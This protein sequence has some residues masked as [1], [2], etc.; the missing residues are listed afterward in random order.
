M[1]EAQAPPWQNGSTGSSPSVGAEARRVGNPNWVRG[2][3]SPNPSGRP[4]GSTP[5]TKLMER[6][7]ADA[8]GIVDAII[9]RALEGDTG[10]ASLIMSRLLPGLKPQSAPVEFE[11]DAAMPAA[12]QIEQIISAIAAGGVPTDVGKQLIDAIE[13]LS[14]VRATEELEA[15]IAALE[16]ARS[17]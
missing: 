6:I 9:A 4:K 8:D 10:A 12:R 13:A 1:S 7:L 2:M 11:Y 17:A 16:E 14:Q 5:Q 3:R 15:R